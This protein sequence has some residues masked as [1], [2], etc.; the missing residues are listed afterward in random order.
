MTSIWCEVAF[1]RGRPQ[2]SVLLDIDAGRFRA[3]TIGAEPGTAI[4]LDG[5]T[6]P[7]MANAHSHAFHRALRSRTQADRGTFWT[8]RE[9]MYRAAE[10][11]EPDSYHRLARAVFAEMALAGVTCVGE[12]HYLHHQPDGTLYNDPNEMGRALLAAADD[13][14]IRITL[15]DTLYLHGGIDVTGYAAPVGAQAR[16]TDGTADAWIERID[17]LTPTDSQHVGAAIHSVRAVDPDSMT[18]VAKW[19]AGSGAP[20]HAHVSEQV[21]ENVAC[22]AHHGRTPVAV[23]DEAG[24]LSD[25]FCAVHATHL[26]AADVELLAA[27]DSTVVLCPTTERDLGDGIGPTGDFASSGV[28][29]ALGSD[30]H[31]VIDLLEEA[32]ALELDERLRS[33]QR[34]IHAATDLLA[35]ATVVGHRTLGWND[36]GSITIG[37]HADLVTISLNSVRTAGTTHATAVESAVFASTAADITDVFVDGRHIVADHRHEAIDVAAALDASIKE[38]MDDD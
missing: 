18:A 2:P 30:S 33:E 15:L 20:V 29:M 27:T 5:L 1:V 12:F 17:A 36:A 31:A 24:V 9:L 6:I 14:G 8:W 10:R 34:G 28:P 4:R 11:L 32:R 3:I 23:F 35:M 13:A 22:V 21:A 16:F 37:N 7:G 25:R 26:D 19:A 38:L